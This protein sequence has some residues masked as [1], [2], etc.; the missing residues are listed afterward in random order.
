LK[1]KVPLDFLFDASSSWFHFMSLFLV[2]STSIEAATFMIQ[3]K[4]RHWIKHNI[5]FMDMMSS[6]IMIVLEGEGREEQRNR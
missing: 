3:G 5:V 2:L 1:S 4:A 6:F